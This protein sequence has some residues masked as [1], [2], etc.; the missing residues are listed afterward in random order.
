[1]NTE[2]RNDP[3]LC[4]TSKTAFRYEP[5]TFWEAVANFNGTAIFLDAAEN[6]LITLQDPPQ[7]AAAA[8][9]VA[10]ANEYVR[11]I[12]FQN[13]FLDAIADDPDPDF[14]E[15]DDPAAA[16][17]AT[18]SFQ[19]SEATL[20]RLLELRVQALE[21]TPVSPDILTVAAACRQAVIAANCAV[22]LYHA[23]RISDQSLPLPERQ[24]HML[25]SW[26]N[27]ANI[28]RAVEHSHPPPQVTDA[29]GI[30]QEACH[31]I[32]QHRP[33]EVSAQAVAAG[34]GL[35]QT[36]LDQL[37]EGHPPGV[38]Y[39]IEDTD[40][41]TWTMAYIY[42]G[43]VYVK[44]VPEPYQHPMDQDTAFYHASQ[45]LAL[46]K[47]LIPHLTDIPDE[48]DALQRKL[49]LQHCLDLQMIDC[50]LHNV[51]HKELQQFTKA[52]WNA[53]RS[54]QATQSVIAALTGNR[55]MAT[56]R[57]ARS[58]PPTTPLLNYEQEQAIVRAARNTGADDETTHEI[59]RRLG[60]D[61]PALTTR[62]PAPAN[63]DSVAFMMD[64]TYQLLPDAHDTALAVALALGWDQDSDQVQ[65]HIASL[66][67]YAEEGR[68]D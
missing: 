60:I 19:Q 55:P 56:A 2:L 25:A 67:N 21:Q 8:S 68:L 64:T 62:L 33:F 28:L 31:D 59:C 43:A 7:T 58:Q 9:T 44:L 6:L 15:G 12:W 36:A 23:S 14:D 40:C 65:E 57:V 39:L 11:R 16:K 35:A 41:S 3:W 45:L 61:P 49:V 17:A 22:V 42:Q 18:D 63:W 37:A 20:G 38:E 26:A 34:Q 47:T 52:A 54:H 50:H 53:T 46:T 5:P 10:V 66:E 1:M 30:L 48:Q 32:G 24:G 27:E 51:T 13:I 29:V 4:H